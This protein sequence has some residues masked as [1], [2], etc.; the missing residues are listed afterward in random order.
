[1]SLDPSTSPESTTPQTL[2]QPPRAKKLPHTRQFHGRTFVD[3]YEWLREKDS[4]EVRAYLEEENAWTTHATSHLSELQDRLFEE[5]KARVQETDMSLPVRSGEWWYFS[6]TQESK[7]YASMCR[8]PVASP[9]D[10]T[11]PVID[12]E[13]PADN[14]QVFLDCNALAEGTEFFSLGA[15]SVTRDG[16]LLAYSVDTTGEERFTMRFKDLTTGED[17]P[18]VIE[19]V[20]YGATWVGSDT[21]YYQKVDAAWRPHQIWKHTIGTPVDQDELIFQEDD[22]HFW[23]GVGTTRSER[24]LLVHSGSKITSENWYLDLQDPDAQLTCIKPRES[25]VEYGV[26][27]AIVG[28]QDFWL[29]IH[30]HNGVNSELA[31]HP[32]GAISSWGDATTLVPHRTDA[33][34]EGV[35]VFSS[36]LVL[37]MRENALETVYVMHL[38]QE[39][40]AGAAGFGEFERLDFG[41]ELASVGTAGN[42]EW[43]APVLRVGYSSFTTP[44]RVYD[45]VLA[46]GER[47]LRK[48]QT[49]LA[50]PDGRPFNP[51]HYTSSRLWVQASDGELIPVSLIHRVDVPLTQE[52]PVLLYGYG[53]Y[54]AS[55]DP[56]FSYFRLSMLDRGVVYAI[57]HVRGGGEMGRGWYDN[58]K[59]LSKLNTF[60]DFVAVADHLI[61]S[62]MTSPDK[63]VAE[64]GSAGGMLM[65]A[66]ANLAGDRFAGIEAVVPFVDPL[67]S[68]L[69]PELPLTVTEWD[70]W[71]D[72]Y[73][74]PAVYDYMAAYSPYENITADKKYPPILAVTSLNDTRVLYVEPA[75]WVAKL[76][77]VAGADVLLK[78]DMDA[79][80]GGVSGRYER[81]RQ[82]AFETAWELDRMGAVELFG[83]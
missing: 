9:D 52:N 35:D 71:G 31:Y 39:G 20:F 73:H 80:H 74:D 13:H 70:E 16:T 25:G 49:V 37:E 55:I 10:W 72:P 29:V 18:D 15:A 26:D 63:M 3:D 59:A 7:S 51:D 50:D 54:E 42:T 76:R 58:G 40:D 33:R 41:E 38:S 65:G 17:L 64:G 5:V 68:M 36:H 57:A 78:T 24:F 61:A 27:H 66:V 43:N 67:T 56:G 14:E 22:E 82:S 53:S 1:M 79:G 28:G 69:M 60:T 4:P 44:A 19:D 46:T 34:V 75:K 77:D 32:V 2:T 81:W 83:R 6:R 11:P 8:I 12:P 48:E 23:T 47:L 45:V 21:M 62:G 30:N